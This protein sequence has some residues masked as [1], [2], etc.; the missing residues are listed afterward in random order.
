MGIRINKKAGWLLVGYD[1][2]L[3]LLDEKFTFQDFFNKLK[4]E[5]KTDAYS[6]RY[7]ISKEDLDTRLID[8]ITDVRNEYDDE[9][10]PMYLFTPPAM[11]KF[12]HNRNRSV[13]YLDHDGDA[14]L[15]IKYLHKELYPYGPNFVVEKTLKKIDEK[16]RHIVM[17]N[18]DTSKFNQTLKDELSDL[19][20]DL[21]KNLKEQVFCVAPPVVVEI[22]RLLDGHIDIHELKPVLATYWV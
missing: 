12:W 17:A 18:M 9:S 10:P 11:I 21:E 16:I 22:L 2:D 20:F 1:L 8:C 13:D 19:G 7:G 6:D 15:Q 3:S 14:T 4:L 5:E